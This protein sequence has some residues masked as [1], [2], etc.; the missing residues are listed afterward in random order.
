MCPWC[1]PEEENCKQ[2]I[3]PL[4]I[5]TLLLFWRN[6]SGSLTRANWTN[7]CK[8]LGFCSFS[9]ICMYWPLLYLYFPLLYLYYPLL[10]LYLPLFK[11]WFTIHGFTQFV[12]QHFC[13]SSWFKFPTLTK[14]NSAG[15]PKLY[16]FQ[17][18]MQSG[19]GQIQTIQIYSI[20]SPLC[21]P[22][23][24]GMSY[25]LF[26]FLSISPYNIPYLLKVNAKRLWADRSR[27][28]PSYFNGFRSPR[29]GD[30]FFPKVIWS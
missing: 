30:H 9:P 6:S 8:P 23:N 15:S 27:L 3:D 21:G 16:I 10:Y 29:A 7:C 12:C 19:C 2:V 24:S 22:Q 1:F 13:R 20:H 17:K 5:L 14:T 26:P 25:L 11:A 4:L 28:N 18:W